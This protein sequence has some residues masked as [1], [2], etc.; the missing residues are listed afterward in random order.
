MQHHSSPSQG[1]PQVSVLMCTYNRSD[2]VHDALKSWLDVDK[3]CCDVELVVVDNASTDDTKRVVDDMSNLHKGLFRY[4]YEPQSGLSNARN[5]GI[6]EA[7]GDIIA[8][9][10]DDV[11]FHSAWLRELVKIV[12]A[13]AEFDCFGGNTIP[14]FDGQRP[15]W[16]EDSMLHFYGATLSGSEDKQMHYPEHPFGV[17]MAFR[18]GVFTKVGVFNPNLGRIG[19][20]LLSNEESEL[21]YRIGQAGLKVYYSSSATVYHRVPEERI[22]QDWLMRRS[23][24]QGISQIVL[25]TQIGKVSRIDHAKKFLFALRRFLALRINGAIDHSELAVSLRLQHLRGIIKQTFVELVRP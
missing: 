3:D 15:D 8:F 1:Q 11:F 21:F 12:E 25:D 6:D 10:D 7:K 23:Y 22:T 13:N 2:L 18:R 24:W 14:H 9:V 4:A 5:R 20:S 16:L 17:N 19:Y